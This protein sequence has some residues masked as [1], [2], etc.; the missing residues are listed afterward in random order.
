MPGTPLLPSTDEIST[1]CPDPA[2]LNISRAV[3]ICTRAATRLVSMVALLAH[4]LP[5]PSGAPLPIPAL[6]ITRSIPPSSSDSPG[7]DHPRDHPAGLVGQRREHLGHLFV[8][9]DVELGDRHP[10]V[11]VTRGE[12][13]L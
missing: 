4:S 1:R 12:L 5:E 6:T 2:F 13:G 7:F 8:V 9:V 11:R 3:S 10:D